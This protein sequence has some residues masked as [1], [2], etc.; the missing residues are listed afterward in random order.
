MFKNYLNS[1]FRIKD[2]GPLKYFL[3]LEVA[4]G[5][6]GLF[7]SQ[8]KYALEIEEECG[9]FGSKPVDFPIEENHNLALSTGTALDDPSRY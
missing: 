8:R 6:L 1:C 9:L 4:R 7:I 5:P 2:L 3:G